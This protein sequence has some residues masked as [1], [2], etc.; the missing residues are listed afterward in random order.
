LLVD[1]TNF[2]EIT[3]T[4]WL[5]GE[6]FADEVVVARDGAEAIDYLFRPGRG[7]PEMPCVVFLDLNM[8]RLGGFGVLEKMRKEEGTRFV[9]VV[10]LTSSDHPH[11]VLRAYESGTSSYG[12]KLHDGAPWHEVVRY[13][14]EVNLT[15][16]L[17]VR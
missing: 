11:D 10:I 13:W 5:M 2:A 17:L 14:A 7:A 8:P 6:G 12:D 4:F 15:P 9:P 1:D 16:Y 3:K